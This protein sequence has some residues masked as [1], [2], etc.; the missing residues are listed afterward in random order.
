MEHKQL[1]KSILLSIITLSVASFLYVNV[2]AALCPVPVVTNKS[3]VP[4]TEMPKPSG[5][6]TSN[7]DKT[8]NMETSF[9]ISVLTR[10]IVVV[11]KV[12][13]IR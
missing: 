8:D 3:V 7:D 11:D 6:S 9:D 1:H 4:C 2:H 12:L 10:L 5:N 13:S